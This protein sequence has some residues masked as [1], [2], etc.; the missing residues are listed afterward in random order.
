MSQRAYIANP[1]IKAK[2]QE[3]EF[4]AKQIKEYIKCAEN[5]IY[6]IEKYIKIV[7]L[8]VGLVDFKMYKFQ[9]KM[10]NAFHNN[11]FTIC[12]VGR[13][14]GKSV[15]VISFILW[16]LLFNESKKVALLANKAATSRELLQRM[17]LAYEHLPS[18]I[19]QG[20]GVWNKGSFELENGSSIISSSTSSS[21]IRGSSF[22]L[23]FLDEFAFVE[24]HIAEDFFRSV[25]PTITSGHETK[26]IIVSTPKGMNHYYKM[27]MDAAD[28]YED[29]RLNYPGSPH[30]FHA[31]LF[32]L[33]SR[34]NAYR[35]ESY[36]AD[37]LIRA[38]K[39]MKQIVKAFPN[40]IQS[41]REYL[42]QE[43]ALIRHK[44]AERDWSMAQYYLKKGENRAAQVYLEKITSEFDDTAFAN[45]ASEETEKMIGLPAEPSQPAE[46]FVN[47]F[48]DSEAKAKPVI[49]A[50]QTST[51]TR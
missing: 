43:A 20:V 48:P 33:K 30:Q 41:E 28:T 19:Q 13:Q 1:L 6:F 29:L 16:Y 50:R 34:L 8:D 11:R 25:Y 51:T 35:G 26:M 3:Q 14:S 36:S 17:Q 10:I 39:L 9:H 24:S 2:F 12:K 47:L 38:D 49:T 37:P 44:L 46:W 22:N 42:S 15:T 32:E 5:P 27:W 21:A 23:V 18:W 40:E 45:A 4:T 31:H 7:S